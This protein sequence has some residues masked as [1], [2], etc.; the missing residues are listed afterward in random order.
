MLNLYIKDLAERV[1]ATFV[2]TLLPLL[3]ADGTN[4]IHLDWGQMLAVAGGAAVVSALKGLLARLKGDSDSASL[5][6]LG[7]FD[8]TK[9]DSATTLR[10]P[11]RG[12][13]G[14]TEG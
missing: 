10:R 5:T 13:Y 4:L 2:A 11:V 6:T 9:A 1:A 12:N 3:G 7:V 8:T 14:D